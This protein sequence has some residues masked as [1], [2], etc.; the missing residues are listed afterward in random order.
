KKLNKQLF[1]QGIHQQLS[2]YLLAIRSSEKA[3]AVL[4]AS[5]LEPAGGFFVSLRPDLGSAPNRNEPLDKNSGEEAGS[6]THYGF[7]DFSLINQLDR[8]RRRDQIGYRITSDPDTLH[9]G[10]S[11]GPMQAGEF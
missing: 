2:V 6:Y 4:N 11:F 7:F 8:A 1:E 3:R 10:G 5:R 9:R